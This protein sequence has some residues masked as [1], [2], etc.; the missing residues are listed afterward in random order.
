MDKEQL[1][2]L[3][4]RGN[5]FEL[6]AYLLSGKLDIGA[7][8]PSGDPMIL[9]AAGMGD[10]RLDVTKVLVRNG[11]DINAAIGGMT[12]LKWIRQPTFCDNEETLAYLTSVGAVEKDISEDEKTS[13]KGNNDPPFLLSAAA[14]EEIA[15]YPLAFRLNSFELKKSY[16]YGSDT[17]QKEITASPD[18]MILTAGI[19]IQNKTEC[20]MRFSSE[21][22]SVLKQPGKK[23][24]ARFYG[25]GNS[26]AE[27][28]KVLSME[29]KIAGPDEKPIVTF[30][31]R[32][33]ED[34]TFLEWELAPGKKYED[35]LVYLIHS[36]ETCNKIGFTY[37]NEPVTYTD[38][39]PLVLSFTSLEIQQSYQFKSGSSQI[40]TTASSDYKFLIA[41]VSMVN[42]ADFAIRFSSESFSLL[43]NSEQKVDATFYGA[44][45]EIA[46]S[47]QV[48]FFETNVD[49]SGN[50]FNLKIL[51]RLCPSLSFIEWELGA[52]YRRDET[53]VYLIPANSGKVKLHFEYCLAD[54]KHYKNTSSENPGCFIASAAFG[55]PLAREVRI[56]S[57]FRD[58]ILL[59]S[60]SGTDFVTFYYRVSPAMSRYISRYRFLKRMTRIILKP[61]IHLAGIQLSHNN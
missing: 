29:T 42:N 33:H 44:G 23:I 16:K 27:S 19:T 9:V 43:N 28:G 49:K 4:T 25:V 48:S 8:L 54:G 21:Q 14:T 56:L 10:S 38:K 46:K 41:K 2:Y 60:K 53:L 59:K 5:A 17:S 3:I 57:D 52:H 1:Y 35:T 32:L 12:L 37:D 31:G 30:K 18:Y 13:E 36:G 61:V 58:L 7:L 39:S 11:A 26:I 20:F 15:G 24:D 34:V 51:G 22:F 55:T 50:K 6:E 40:E 47:G 45:D